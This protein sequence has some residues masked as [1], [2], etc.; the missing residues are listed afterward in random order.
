MNVFRL[1]RTFP[2][3]LNVRGNICASQTCVWPLKTLTKS[4]KTS[5]LEKYTFTQKVSN[6]NW[7]NCVVQ[8]RQRWNVC[9]ELKKKH[10]TQNITPIG[11][12]NK[13]GNLLV[14][15][16]TLWNKW[17]WAH[18]QVCWVIAASCLQSGIVPCRYKDKVKIVLLETL[19]KWVFRKK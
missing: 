14:T 3:K 16:I 9:V 8:T 13:C 17:M 6:K 18:S 10:K 1:R 19:K 7:A 15:L 2:G 5:L 12:Q 11:S 4:E